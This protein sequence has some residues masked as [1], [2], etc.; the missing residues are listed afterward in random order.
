MKQQQQQQQRRHVFSF[1]IH[2]LLL[3]LSLILLAALLD[4]GGLFTGGND[5]SRLPDLTSISELESSRPV[6]SFLPSV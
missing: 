5:D 3:L 6:S 2:V 1:L 4:I